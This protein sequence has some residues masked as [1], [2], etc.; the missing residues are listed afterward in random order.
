MFTDGLTAVG[1][2]DGGGGAEAAARPTMLEEGG[3]AV[4]GAEAIMTLL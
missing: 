2:P 3:R 1:R 4:A